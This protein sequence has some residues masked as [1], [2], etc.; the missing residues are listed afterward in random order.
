[1]AQQTVVQ[2]H[3]NASQ[4]APIKKPTIWEWI[5]F[6]LVTLIHNGSPFLDKLFGHKVKLTAQQ[7]GDKTGQVSA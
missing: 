5:L 1:M 6:Y 7:I 3:P 4:K 2:A